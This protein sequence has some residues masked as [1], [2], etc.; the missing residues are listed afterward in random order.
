MADGHGVVDEEILEAGV[1]FGFDAAGG[2][3]SPKRIHCHD[4]AG[5]NRQRRFMRHGI[6]LAQWAAGV[7]GYTLKHVPCPTRRPRRDTGTPDPAGVVPDL[8]APAARIAQGWRPCAHRARDV[9]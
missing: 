3:K 6:S 1:D 2:E 4:E 7:R 9:I 5:W 8:P